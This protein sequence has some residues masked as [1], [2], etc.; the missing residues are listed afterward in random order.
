MAVLWAFGVS[1]NTLTLAG[2]AIAWG[3]RWTDALS[4]G[5]SSAVGE[6]PHGEPEVGREVSDCRPVGGAE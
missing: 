4:N 5:K 1:M 6:S 2:L 3:G